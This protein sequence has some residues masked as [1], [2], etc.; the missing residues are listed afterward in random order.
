MPSVQVLFYLTENVCVVAQYPC[1][2]VLRLNQLLLRGRNEKVFK[3]YII[4]ACV[5]SYIFFL[6]RTCLS[7]SL[8]VLSCL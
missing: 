1:I 7:H 6:L 8:L 3:V 5:S 2:I 4:H